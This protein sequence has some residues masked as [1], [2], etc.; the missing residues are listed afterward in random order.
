MRYKWL[1]LQFLL[2]KETRAVTELCTVDP[3]VSINANDALAACQAIG[4]T[5]WLPITNEDMALRYKKGV[6]G[7]NWG[8][9]NFYLISGLWSIDYGMGL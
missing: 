8:S 5:I 2:A 9:P 6:I 1:I 4:G 7:L 3:G